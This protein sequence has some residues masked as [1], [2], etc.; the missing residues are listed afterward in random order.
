MAGKVVVH[1]YMSLDGFIAGPAHDM[2]WVFEQSVPESANEVMRTT[3]AMLAGMRTQEVGERDVGK[4]SGEAYDGHWSGPV[5]VLTHNDPD[6]NSNEGVT[7]VSGDIRDVVARGLEAAGGKSLEI[8]GTQTADQC[9]ELGLVDEVRVH[10]API[11][12]GDGIRLHDVAG[13]H[14]VDL[15]LIDTSRTGEVVSLHYRVKR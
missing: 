2:D 9:L 15:E 12:L 10:V 6:A 14:R 1:R 3:G 13:G 8:L 4:G 7:Y 11:L 5:F